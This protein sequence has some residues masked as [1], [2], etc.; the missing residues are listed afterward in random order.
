MNKY[1][2]CCRSCARGVGVQK[3]KK[4]NGFMLLKGTERG[5]FFAGTNPSL[6]IMMPLLVVSM[7]VLGDDTQPLRD[8]L[9]SLCSLN[10]EGEFG[11]CCERYDI[12]SVTLSYSTARDCFIS[13]L[14]YTS[15]S[16]TSLFVFICLSELFIFRH[17]KDKGLTS[18]GSGVFSSLKN[19][20]TL[21]IPLFHKILED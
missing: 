1:C 9:S 10:K 6:I 15:V 7:C 14:S 20:K 18:L 16:L 8:T 3:Q 5:S 2:A 17:F 11:S 13:S 12:S 4:G 21:S 19:L